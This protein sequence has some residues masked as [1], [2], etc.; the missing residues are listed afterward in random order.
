M[1]QYKAHG[2]RRVWLPAAAF[3]ALRRWSSARRLI[4]LQVIE[5]ETYAAPG[6]A[7]AR[8][9]NDTIYAR[10]GS[11]LDRNGDV[12]AASVDTWDIYVNARAWDDDSTPQTA[13]EAARAGPQGDRHR[14]ARDGRGRRSGSTSASRRDFDY[15]AGLELICGELAGRRR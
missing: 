1:A 7:R 9:A 5:H 3:G 8:S 14:A 11:I 12:L 4:Q 10:R 15:E 2:T 6:G 13:L